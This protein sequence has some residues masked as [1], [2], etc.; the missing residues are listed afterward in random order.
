MALEADRF[1]SRADTLLFLACV[2]LSLVAMAL[3]VAWRDP[4][5][6]LLRRSVLAPFLALQEQ[7]T[8]FQTS[9][10]RFIELER[11]RDS[12]ALAAT[13]LPALRAE[14]ERLRGLLGLAE[15]LGGGYVPAEVLHQPEPTS[16]LTLVIR[17]GSR[18]GVRALAPVVSP[19]GLLGTVNTVDARTST[20]VTWA[21]P[22]FRASA[23][24][25]DGSV[26]GIVSSAGGTERGGTW[27]LELRGVPYR[28]TVAAG[29][30]IVTAGLGGV[31][32]RGIPIGVVAD[33]AA[34][35]R[36]WERTY[37]VRPL[38]QPAGVGHVIV[39]VVPPDADAGQ[40]FTPREGGQ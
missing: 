16:A 39:L 7:S 15:R 8:Q 11:Q 17:A 36:G 33:T 3:P 12:A 31:I 30:V 5:A 4:I 35:Q 10:A 38:A 25:A 19:D 9:R 28:T 14:N 13:F 2:S 34:E 18:Q 32:P 20:V 26:Y 37:L 22:D 40:A 27:L 24:A 23:M 21:H 6:G 29:T 1:G